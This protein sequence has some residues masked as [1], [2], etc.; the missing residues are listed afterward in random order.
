MHVLSPVLGPKVAS[1]PGWCWPRL[2]SPVGGQM[3]G[4]GICHTSHDN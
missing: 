1:D 2:L 3:I 4:T